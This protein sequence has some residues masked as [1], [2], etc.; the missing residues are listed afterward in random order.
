MLCKGMDG[1]FCLR[2]HSIQQRDRHII[3][4]QY[5]GTERISEDEGN[6]VPLVTLMRN[7]RGR[8][9]IGDHRVTKDPF[10]PPYPATAPQRAEAVNGSICLDSDP[11]HGLARKAHFTDL[12][13]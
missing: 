10:V 1:V 7:P 5:S 2:E 9:D 4:A 6:G 3:S 13:K 11:F 8:G 12:G